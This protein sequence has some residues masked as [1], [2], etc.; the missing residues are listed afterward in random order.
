M[1]HSAASRLSPPQLQ[2]R[3]ALPPP[4]S[5]RPP[6]PLPP[7]V[8]SPRPSRAPPS[9]P[10]AFTAATSSAPASAA[11]IQASVSHFLPI[12]GH[13]VVT[14]LRGLQACRMAEADP[15]RVSE[16]AAQ[17]V[18][19]EVVA[20]LSSDSGDESDSSSSSSSSSCSSSSSGR[21]PFYRSI[22]VPGP[23]RSVRRTRQVEVSWIG[24]LV[25]LEIVC[26]LSEIFKTNVTR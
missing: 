3:E 20:I 26:R 13:A 7:P 15:N 22:S 17:G 11:T 4:L 1:R 19:E 25:Q 2:L 24:C 18:D 5:P 10:A 14:T 8:Q 9:A 16:P 6:L 21:S 12:S 23:S